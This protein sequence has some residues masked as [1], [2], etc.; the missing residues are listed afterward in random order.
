MF[1]VLQQFWGRLQLVRRLAI[2]LAVGLLWTNPP[3]FASSL[4]SDFAALKQLAAESVTYSVAMADSKPA[5]VEFYAEWCA[6]CRSMAP[7]IARLHEEYG[8]RVNFVML[9][10][11][12][13]Q[14]ALQIRKFGVMGVPHYAF[15]GSRQD[16]AGDRA[17]VSTA[18][19]YQP[20]VIMA[21]GLDRLLTSDVNL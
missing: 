18:I 2:A 13:P 1:G 16:E 14:W 10:I 19:G 21:T 17:L 6:T 12:D 4:L 3:A 5:L 15:V 11:D 20:T 7:A 8:D 9:D